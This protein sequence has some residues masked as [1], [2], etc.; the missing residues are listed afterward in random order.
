MTSKERQGQIKLIIQRDKKVVVSELSAQFNVTEETIRRD[1]EKFEKQGLIV[2]TYGGAV[3]NTERTDFTISERYGRSLVNADEKR[4]IADTVVSSGI[5]TQGS[6]IMADRSSTVMELL[7][8]LRDREDLTILVHSLET[9]IEFWKTNLNIMLTGGVID[10][11]TRSLTGAFTH[12]TIQSCFVD[13]VILGCASIRMKDGFFDTYGPDA[14]LKKMMINQGKKV[15]LLADHTKFEQNALVK[16][17]DIDNVDIFVTDRKPKPEWME[18][19]K[20]CNVQVLYP[21]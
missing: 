17:W 1:L 2:R 18:I 8:K 5:I 13:F 6:T 20:K 4:A 11:K 15:I 7:R 10:K 16:L 12:N 3:L 9:A 21:K 19:F 14:E